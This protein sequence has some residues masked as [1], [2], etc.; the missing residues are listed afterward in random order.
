MH[1]VNILSEKGFRVSVA[2]CQ[3]PGSLKRPEELVPA[4][5]ELIISRDF[6]VQRR[7]V[8]RLIAVWQWHRRVRGIIRR[9]RPDIVIAHD[10]EGAF[11]VGNMPHRVGARM[12][13]HFHHN[14]DRL[15]RGGSV[16]MANRYAYRNARQA[17]LITN[18]DAMRAQVFAKEASIDANSIIVVPN[19]TRSIPAVPPPN[20]REALDSAIPQGAAIVMYHGAIGPDHGLEVAV[21][22]LP[23]WPRNSVFVLKG[24][25][26]ADFAD[27]IKGLA[28]SLGV[29]S[30]VIFYDPGFQPFDE[31]YAA[32]A[33]AD[34]GWTVFEPVHVNWKYQ[35]MGSNK[36]F[37]CM[38]LGVPQIAD[39]NP[40]AVEFIQEQ[41][42]GLCIPW[43]SPEAAAK[44]V[45]RLLGDDAFR[46]S[47][48]QHCR[49][50]HLNRYN[51]DAQFKPVV[52]WIERGTR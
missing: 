22:S 18:C 46:K 41:G 49:E 12:I 32:I 33:S 9:L 45:N 10:A 20:L 51:Y 42:F 19:C 50:L 14:P 38:A 26:H 25:A 7:L 29:S 31:H 24:K 3:K 52:E 5:E 35:A 21:R 6:G 48:A 11:A 39:D 47:V 15:H 2:C 37:E 16:G 27:R 28:S 30:R 8:G 40:G 1:Q 36:R 17:D 34:I 4:I 43:N 44:A 13:W 23:Q